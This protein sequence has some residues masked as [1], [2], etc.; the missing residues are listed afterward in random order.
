MA[1]VDDTEVMLVILRKMCK[2]I[3]SYAHNGCRDTDNKQ[4][5]EGHCSMDTFVGNNGDKYQGG[6]PCLF[7]SDSQGLDTSGG[8]SAPETKNGTER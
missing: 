2:E 8:L 5:N 7:V 3:L 1:K 4:S 6:Q